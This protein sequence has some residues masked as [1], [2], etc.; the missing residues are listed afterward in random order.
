MLCKAHL[1]VKCFRPYD[2]VFGA[3]GGYTTVEVIMKIVC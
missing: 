1:P 3:N 2:C